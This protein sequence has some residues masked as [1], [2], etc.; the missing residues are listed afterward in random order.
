M[1]LLTVFERGCWDVDGESP[2]QGHFPRGCRYVVL[3]FHFHIAQGYGY[4][5]INKSFSSYLVRSAA[6]EK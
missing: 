4:A 1:L 2:R 6:A 3:L 5:T